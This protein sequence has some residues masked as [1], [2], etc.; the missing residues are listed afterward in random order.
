MRRHVG[1]LRPGHKGRRGQALIFLTLWL[2][3]LFGITALVVD[4]GFI[5]FYQ[6]ELDA[7]TQAAVLA[8][9]WAM[10]QAGATTT[11]TTTA[12]TNYSSQSGK[13]NNYT[14][15]PN[16]SIMS[17]YPKF[18][19]LSTVT[20][21]FGIQCYGPSSSNALVVAQQ[22]TMPLYFFR[23]FG[24]STATLTS[25]ATAAM[26]GAAPAPYNVAMILDTTASMNNTD[27]DSNC[28]STR[29]SCA[30]SGARILLQ[31][32]SPCPPGLSSC[33][34][35]TNG[36]VANSVDRVSL[37]TFPPVTTATVANDTNCGSASPSIA[38]YATP[39][40]STST[41]QIVDFSSDFRTSDTATSLSSTSKVVA[42]VGGKSGCNAMKAV[43]GVGTYLA[44]SIYQAQSYLAAEKV[45]FPTADNVMILLSDGDANATSTNL[46]GASTS[47]GTYP[48]TRQQCHQ[49]VT[50]AQTAAAAGTKVY[51][52][53]YGA[54][55]S[56]C[57]TDTSPTITPCQTMQQIASSPAYFFS[58]YT[59]TGGSSSC[60][61]AAQPITGLNQIFQT[62]LTDL[63]NV[64]LIPNNTT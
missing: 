39:F 26:K 60:I 25:V 36:N 41:Y 42:A 14:N 49:A 46:P 63:L 6:T 13:Y 23:L 4:I 19:C 16:V 24:G 56:G 22:V 32:L 5:H 12:V 61:S 64:K 47:S 15:L 48:S 50:A 40:P 51:T 35:V 27:S 21:V 2:P 3:L 53:A 62:I 38:K 1:R 37:L 59:A 20:S 55:S 58:D 43:G 10:S 17:G 44:Q 57:S 18:K 45:L 8:G 52:V 29:I 34:A 31:G 9:A 11:S 28:N 54:T 33:G 7:S 30:L